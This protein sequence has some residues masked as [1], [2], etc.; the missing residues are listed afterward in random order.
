MFQ[1]EDLPQMR[2]FSPPPV[3]PIEYPP[4]N[5]LRRISQVMCFQ[6]YKVLTAAY[7]SS[8]SLCLRGQN[9]SLSDKNVICDND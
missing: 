4:A 9:I 8:L 7:F 1:I 6:D 5:I 3:P 2:S